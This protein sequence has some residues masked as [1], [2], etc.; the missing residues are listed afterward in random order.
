MSHTCIPNRETST[1]SIEQINDESKKS[2]TDVNMNCSN[3]SDGNSENQ[4]K[5]WKDA[6][7][8]SES[9]ELIWNNMDSL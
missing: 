9:Q 5:K 8:I 7:I 2:N 6:F 4:K 3:H 1:T